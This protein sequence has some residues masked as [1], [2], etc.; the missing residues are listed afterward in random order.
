MCMIHMPVVFLLLLFATSEK[1]SV[2]TC[3]RYFVAVGYGRISIALLDR[4]RKDRCTDN[5]VV[6]DII[7]KAYDG[8]LYSVL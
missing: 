5:E 7:K 1:W 3:N 2:F 4:K 8:L 6:K